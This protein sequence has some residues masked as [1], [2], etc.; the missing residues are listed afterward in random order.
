MIRHQALHPFGLGRGALAALLVLSSL[1]TGSL[2]CRAQE[3]PEPPTSLAPELPDDPPG[4]AAWSINPRTPAATVSFGR[5]TSH[6]VNVDASGANIVGD[7]ANEPSIAVDPNDPS[8]IAIGWRQFDT[9]ASNFRQ[10]GYGYSTDG[11]LSWTTGTIDPGVFRSDPV[12]GFD[13]QGKFLYNSLSTPGGS[14]ACS[15]FPSTDGGM[16][17]GS[18]AF[19]YG[20]DKQWMTV[21]RTGG[22]GHD[23]AYESWSSSS[24]PTPGNT[25][26]RS[27]DDGASF[28]SP[29]SIP[30][31]PMWGTLDVGP[32]GKLYV[33]GQVS[34]GNIYVGRSTDAMNPLVTPSFSTQTVNLGG[35]IVTGGPNPG[36]LLGQLWVAVDRSS[37]P[38]SGW[39]YALGSVRTATDPL[40]VMFARST[41]G[42]QT[43]SAPVRVN[44]DPTGNRAFQW[45]GTLSVS[46]D[47]RMDAIWNDTRGSADS[48]H[49]ALYY[50]FSNDGGVTWSPNEQASPEW[51]STV[52][53]PNQQKIGDYY[54]MISR[55]DGADL[56][57]AATF[58]GEEDVYLL[59][60]SSGTT[61]VADARPPSLRLTGAPNPFSAST[62]IRFDT[63]AAGGRAALE[64]F[65]AGGRRVTTLVDGFV[66]GGAHVARWTGTDAMGRRVKAGLYFVRLET[67]AGVQSLKLMVMR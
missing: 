55:V 64:V 15:V 14:F 12:L 21:D 49:S 62:T 26:S 47:G 51:I 24:N 20:G 1:A 58:N 7:A 18:G 63:P 61:A 40:D 59:R 13:A 2:P 50:S 5:F 66:A 48:T 6:Q 27:I 29:T 53:W 38:R 8:R 19:A 42:G 56:A 3:P 33:I 17:W 60:I 65:D 31:Q 23:H 41:D 45:F 28:Q 43:W 32:D 52:G 36:G 37:G 4:I 11:G 57:W 67:A 9:I 10:A 16:T 46:P 39:V 34:N 25:F 30:H 54:H 22:T 35:I 44:D